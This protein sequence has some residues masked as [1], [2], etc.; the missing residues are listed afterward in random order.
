MQASRARGAEGI[1]CYD[2]EEATSV[3]WSLV[4]VNMM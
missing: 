4:I 1:C 3:I 2:A